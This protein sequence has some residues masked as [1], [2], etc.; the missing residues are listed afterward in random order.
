MKKAPIT[1]I[2]PPFLNKKSLLDD[3]IEN[4]PM[5]P[6]NESNSSFEMFD[7]TNNNN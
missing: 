3:N 6:F 1:E 2:T 4:E 5:S 7:D